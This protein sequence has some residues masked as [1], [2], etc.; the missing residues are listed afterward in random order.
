MA[1]YGSSGKRQHNQGQGCSI[2]QQNVY[3]AIETN[4]WVLSKTK[5]TSEA[6]LALGVVQQLGQ[7]TKKDGFENFKRKHTLR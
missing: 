5:A 7:A 6:I 1:S 2:S 4:A 3:A